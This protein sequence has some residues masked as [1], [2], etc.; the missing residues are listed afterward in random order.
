[1]RNQDIS[2]R[3]ITPTTVPTIGP[4]IEPCEWDDAEEIELEGFGALENPLKPDSGMVKMTVKLLM[5]VVWTDTKDVAPNCE[6]VEG[7][8]GAASGSES[9]CVGSKKPSD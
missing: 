1:M 8:S 3:I 4:T 6:A 7:L 5:T 2:T 9:G